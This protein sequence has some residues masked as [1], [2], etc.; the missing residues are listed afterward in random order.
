MKD[1]GFQVKS[2]LAL[3]YEVHMGEAFFDKEGPFSETWRMCDRS[4]GLPMPGG[5]VRGYTDL[6]CLYTPPVRRERDVVL[7]MCTLLAQWHVIAN[8]DIT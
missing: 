6:Y 8:C 2:Q 5:G 7:Y 3:T 4:V 1:T